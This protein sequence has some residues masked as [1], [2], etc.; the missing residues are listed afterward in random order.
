MTRQFLT[1]KILLFFLVLKSFAISGLKISFAVFTFQ[2]Y[3]CLALT[4]LTNNSAQVLL[5]RH[6]TDTGKVNIQISPKMTAF[7]F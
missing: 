4:K 3:L 1:K 2:F 6:T 5:R 7:N